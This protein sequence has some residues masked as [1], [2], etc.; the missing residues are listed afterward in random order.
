MIVEHAHVHKGDRRLWGQSVKTIP[1]P[2]VAAMRRDNRALKSRAGWLKN[3]NH[4]E[5]A[6]V[7]QNLTH[8]RKAFGCGSPVIGCDRLDIVIDESHAR[9]GGHFG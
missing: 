3:G 2:E 5:A 6:V 4:P 1:E 9:E 7:R 8:R